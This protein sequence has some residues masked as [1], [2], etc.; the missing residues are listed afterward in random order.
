MVGPVIPANQGNACTQDVLA[1]GTVKTHQLSPE[2]PLGGHVTWAINSLSWKG[3]SVPE[4]GV[5]KFNCISS[6]SQAPEDS[7]WTS[8]PPSGASLW[9]GLGVK[10]SPQTALKASI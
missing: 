3:V 5:K 2:N 1:K 6:T 8:G 9:V 4:E 7:A 10:Q